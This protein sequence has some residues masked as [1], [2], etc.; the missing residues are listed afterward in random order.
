[1]NLQVE[2]ELQLAFEKFNQSGE[3]PIT[4]KKCRYFSDF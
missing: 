2:E 4:D 3:L 1:L